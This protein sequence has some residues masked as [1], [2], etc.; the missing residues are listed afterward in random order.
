[1]RQTEIVKTGIQ[2]ALGPILAGYAFQQ[3]A[4]TGMLPVIAEEL[5]LTPGRVG[6]AVGVGLLV[7]SVIAP[8]LVGGMTRQWLRVA[9][10]VQMLASLALMGLLLVPAPAVAAFALLLAIRIVQ[11]TAAAAT[12]AVA[13]GASASVGRPVAALARLQIGPGL[14][15]AF[16]AA[17]IGPLV[18]LSIVIPLL[19]ALIGATVSLFLLA[20]TDWC[21]PMTTGHHERTPWTA[22][23]AVPFLVQC[24][25]GAGQLGLGPLLAQNFP[26]PRAA[27]IA[28]LCLGTGY[29]ALM[30]AHVFVTPVSTG[31]RPAATLLV[32]ALFLPVLWP[33]PAV[34]VVATALAA[35]TS[36][37]I[38][39]RHLARVISLRPAAAR[40]NAAW[41]GSALLAGL[42]IGAS[43][44]SLCLPLSPVAPF[45]LAC[46]FAL[47]ALLIC[48]RT[49]R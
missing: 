10:A 36:G 41:Q 8:F 5:D 11:G 29:L 40:R 18:R 27:A 17:L 46:G 23:L 26:A 32:A 2:R 31:I 28:G 34:L 15:R 45:L 22:A 20:R 21:L 7:S 9:M 13:Q 48:K 19:P 14:G 12:L 4:L 1:M 38:I 6:L 47:A 35:G 44:A 42:G 25:V 30:L 49:L 16:G 3:T 39:A 33:Q 37:V 43:A 24:A